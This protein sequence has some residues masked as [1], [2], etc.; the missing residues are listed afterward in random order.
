MISHRAKHLQESVYQ[1]TFCSFKCR[2]KQNFVSHLKIHTPEKVYKCETC[3]KSFKYKH[4][5]DSH[6][7]SHNMEKSLS[8]DSCGFHTKYMSHMIAHKRIHAGICIMSVEIVEVVLIL[9][10]FRFLQAIS[11][12]VPIRTVNIRLRRKISLLRTRKPTTEFVRIRVRF[13]DEVSWKNPTWFDTKGS[14]SKRNRSSV[15][16]AITRVRVAIN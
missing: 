15:R 9:G 13:A 12:G 10:C 14:T 11:T 3:S 5:L 2:Q 1:C 16:V 4:N 7:Q 8:C 6:A